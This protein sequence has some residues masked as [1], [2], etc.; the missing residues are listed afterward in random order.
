MD[1]GGLT[2]PKRRAM[3][4]GRKGTMETENEIRDTADEEL[5]SLEWMKDEDEDP[6][7]ADV[8]DGP[9]GA[10][11]DDQGSEDQADEEGTRSPAEMSIDELVVRYRELED[12]DEKSDFL[13]AIDDIARAKEVLEVVGTTIV[14][15]PDVAEGETEIAWD[16][17]WTRSP[18]AEMTQDLDVFA[19]KGLADVK[20][21]RLTIAPELRAEL[22]EQLAVADG[23]P[24]GH[25]H[26]TIALQKAAGIAEYARRE[27]E[28]SIPFGLGGIQQSKTYQ[29]SDGE[30]VLR[31]IDGRGKVR[32]TPIPDGKAPSEL[33]DDVG[34][35]PAEEIDYENITPE[36]ALRLTPTQWMELARRNPH[37]F[38]EH[39]VLKEQ[40][41]RRASEVIEQKHR[42]ARAGGML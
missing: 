1:R 23:L 37:Q 15:A 13:A 30:W 17:Y 25:S 41:L 12:E 26:R 6:Y 34:G 10:A 28:A 11:A 31:E 40:L 19:V 8:A 42:D 33:Y 14:A 7:A 29:R 5:D 4:P 24:V 35:T 18:L 2:S 21:G 38:G 32:E 27:Y 20:A 9:E 22:E 3:S 36:Q 16:E 39:G